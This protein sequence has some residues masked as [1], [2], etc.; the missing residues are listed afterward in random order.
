M[1]LLI[2]GND[3]YRAKK[4]LAAMR[5]RFLVSRDPSGMNAARFEAQRDGVD[6]ALEAV[7]ASPFLAEKKLIILEGYLALPKKDQ[8]RIEEAM[9]KKPDSSNVIFY[10]PIDAEELSGSAFF[11]V[12]A[13]QQYSVECKKLSRGQ[14]VATVVEYAKGRGVAF[15]R[16]TIEIIGNACGDDIVHT[17]IEATKLC[18]FVRG[19]GRSDVTRADAEA[20]LVRPQNNE[21]FGLLDAMI[22]GRRDDA[23]T[24]LRRLE[25]QGE[26]GHALLQTILKQ[27]RNFFGAAD[28]AARGVNDSA[29]VAK[30][31]G[32]HPFVGKKLL[33][34]VRNVTPAVARRWYGDLIEIDRQMK[35]GAKSAFALLEAF[36]LAREKTLSHTR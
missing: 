33:A 23:L 32:I 13:K 20:L 36:I 16:E 9:A 29:T 26:S 2:Y 11:P 1:F 7:F 34:A 24:K 5:E 3:G 6:A 12:L 10:E 25:S 35:T 22:E 17:M 18:D 28:M 27:Y 21:I 14:I 8:Q 15:S 30:K 4:T 31:L 19:S